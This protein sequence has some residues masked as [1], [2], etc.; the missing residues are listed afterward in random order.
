MFGMENFTRDRADDPALCK[1]Y[2]AANARV[3]GR[4]L[5]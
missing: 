1:I 2:R 4:I 3:N 5:H